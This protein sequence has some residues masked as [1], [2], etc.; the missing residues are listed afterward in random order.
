MFDL[1]TEGVAEDDPESPV[2]QTLKWAFGSA[3][4]GSRFEVAEVV[5]APPQLAWRRSG[6][7]VGEPRG[8]A[9][10]V[11]FGDRPGE[12]HGVEVGPHPF[13]EPQFREGALP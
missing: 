9:A 8:A 6:A 7:G 11:E 12:V 2:M 3:V 1:A 13:G 10:G 4:Q 5:A